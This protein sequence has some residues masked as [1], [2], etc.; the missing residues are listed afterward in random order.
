MRI[1]QCM[2]TAQLGFGVNRDHRLARAGHHRLV[3]RGVRLYLL[4]PR[5]R[6]RSQFVLPGAFMKH[7]PFLVACTGS[8][9]ERLRWLRC[10]ALKN[11]YLCLSIAYPLW[12]SREC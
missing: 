8:G 6:R 3:K 9:G 2:V 10:L 1:S 11:L 4:V 7:A 12:L 5:L